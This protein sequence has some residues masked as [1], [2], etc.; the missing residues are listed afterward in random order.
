MRDTRLVAT[1]SFENAAPVIA[2]PPKS[3]ELEPA[4]AVYKALNAAVANLAKSRAVSKILVNTFPL[5][6]CSCLLPELKYKSPSFTGFPTPSVTG[7]EEAAP[8]Y[9]A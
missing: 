8:R 5:Y 2:R 6:T 9:K 3:I 1:A 4:D 7:A